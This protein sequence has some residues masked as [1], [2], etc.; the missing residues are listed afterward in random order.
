MLLYCRCFL[1]AVVQFLSGTPD[2][3]NGLKSALK[4]SGVAEM[5][6]ASIA[7]GLQNALKLIMIRTAAATQS[8]A[9]IEQL[10]SVLQDSQYLPMHDLIEWESDAIGKY[11]ASYSQISHHSCIIKGCK[12][13]TA[14]ILPETAGTARRRAVH[15]V[16]P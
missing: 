6:D 1:N 12:S 8:P 11:A 16:D 2:I 3:M 13:P 5:W 4:V 9:D 10:V 15:P 7:R 14:V